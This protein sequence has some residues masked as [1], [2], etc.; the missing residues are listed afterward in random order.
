MIKRVWKYIKHPI[1]KLEMLEIEIGILNLI[2][3]GRTFFT[4]FAAQ[5]LVFDLN[6]RLCNNIFDQVYYRKILFMVANSNATIF[7]VSEGFFNLRISPT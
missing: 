3:K 7:F 6:T 1:T 5:Y 4:V 2:L